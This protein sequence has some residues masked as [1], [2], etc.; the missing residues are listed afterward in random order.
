[1]SDYDLFAHLYDLEHRDLEQDLDLYLNFAERCD[2]VVLELGCGTGRVTLALGQAG[3]TVVGLDEST[4]MLELAG[5]RVAEAGL[6]AKVRL[7]HLDVRDMAWSERFALAIWPLNGFLHLPSRTDQAL[8]LAKVRQALLPGGFVV[9]DLPNPH[10][11][12]APQSDDQLAIRRSVQTA[13]GDLVTSLVSTRT[14]L[15]DQVQHMTL[16]YDT[17]GCQDGIVRR[18]AAQVELRFVYRYEMAG[19]LEQTGFEVDAVHGSYDLDPYESDS[20]IMLFVAH[21]RRR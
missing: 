7:E 18:T 1:M 8:A 16:L 15:A 19:L 14:D 20:P 3:Y 2:G 6:G 13:Q 11:A 9:V 12:F 10:V 21:T 17:V 4:S 5:A